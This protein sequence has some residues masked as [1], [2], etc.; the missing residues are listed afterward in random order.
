MLSLHKS[1][2]VALTCASVLATLRNR[3]AESIAPL[4][5]RPCP[6]YPTIFHVATKDGT[7]RVNQAPDLFGALSV[8]DENRTEVFELSCGSLLLLQ[9]SGRL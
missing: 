4:P 5:D 3:R 7:G 2:P 6:L 1:C 9:L 8:C